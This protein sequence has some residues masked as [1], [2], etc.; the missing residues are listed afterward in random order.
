MIP[1]LFEVLLAAYRAQGWWP[2]MS[3]AGRRGFD[4]QGYHPGVHP[5][6]ATPAQRFEIAMGAVLTQNT[7]WTNAEKALA[8]LFAA[9][10]RTPGD[11]L[12]FPVARLAGLVRSSG[13][14]HQ[15][16][17]TLR[18]LAGFFSAARSLH[19]GNPPRREALLSVRGVGPETAD[20]ILLYA[21]GLPA[22]VVD[23]Y[24]RRFLTRVGGTGGGGSYGEVQ[25]LFHRALPSDPALFGEYH[26]LIVAHAKA[27]CRARPVCE[28]CPVMP[29]CRALRSSTA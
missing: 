3:R 14:H 23:A 5:W 7:S 1:R 21:F 10:V 8:E 29:R 28:D 15:K 22:F 25:A 9:G 20:S 19:A 17:A 11:V 18:A 2:L 13:Y 26:A 6:P 4:A 27:H 12:A 16:S 24:T